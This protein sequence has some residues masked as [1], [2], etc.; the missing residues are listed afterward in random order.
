MEYKDICITYIEYNICSFSDSGD[1][2]SIGRNI[3]GI[4]LEEQE[5]E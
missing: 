3:I 5:V 4:L 1:I 2:S